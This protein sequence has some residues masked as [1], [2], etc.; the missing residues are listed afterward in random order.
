M[1]PQYGDWCGPGHTAGQNGIAF[2]RADIPFLKLLPVASIQMP[3]G[4]KQPSTLDSACKAHDIAYIEAEGRPNESALKSNADIQLL[5]EITSSFNTYTPEEKVYG[6]MAATAFAAKLALYDLPATTLSGLKN[7]FGKLADYI[8]ENGTPAD[9]FVVTG[10]EHYV[11]SMLVDSWGNV[12]LSRTDDQGTMSLSLGSELDKA[13]FIQQRINEYGEIYD[14]TRINA[15]LQS[16]FFQMS[17]ATDGVEDLQGVVIGKLTQEKLDQFAELGSAALNSTALS[18]TDQSTPSSADPSAASILSTMNVN[19]DNEAVDALDTWFAQADAIVLEPYRWESVDANLQAFWHTGSGEVLAA[20]DLGVALEEAGWTP[21]LGDSSWALPDLAPMFADFSSETGIPDPI[22]LPSYDE[23]LDTYDGFN[24]NYEDYLS[25]SSDL[26]FVTGSDWIS[27]G[28]DYSN[29]YVDP[30]VLKLGAGSVHTTNR[31]GSTV[32]FDMNADGARDKT[33][34]ITA[35]EGFLVIDKNN[36]GIIDNTSEMFSEYLSPKAR[37][38]FGALAA[39]DQNGDGYADKWDKNFGKLKLWIDINVNGVTDQ[40]ELHALNEFGIYAIRT[41]TPK[42]ANHYDN[43][44]LIQS[45][46]SYLANVKGRIHYG[47]VAEVLFNYG[48]QGPIATVYLSDQTSTVRTGSGKVIELLTDKGAQTIN[49]SLSGVNVLIGGAGDRLNAGNAGKSLL[50]GNG[51]TTMNGNAGDVHFIVNG[52]G[53]VVNT[54]SGSSWIEVNG[55]ANKINAT[56]GDVTLDVDGN[57]NAV[58][59]GSGADVVLGGTDNTLTAAAKSHDNDIVVGGEKAIIKVSNADVHIDDHASATLNGKNNDIT[60]DSNAT[61]S[62]KASGGTLTVSGEN[63]VA[64]LTGAFIAMTEG[65]GLTLTGSAHQVVMAGDASLTMKSSGVGSTIYVSGDDNQLN[66][67]RATVILADRAGLDLNGS[68]DRISLLGNAS[69]SATGTA[70]RI[71]AYG[72]GNAV[73][74]EQSTVVEHALAEITLSGTGN[75][76]KVTPDNSPAAPAALGTE[77][78]LQMQLDKAVEN[79]VELALQMPS[80]GIPIDEVSTVGT[81]SLAGSGS[82]LTMPDYMH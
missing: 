21:D 77:L 61:L 56:K 49:A 55:D 12:V 9:P 22:Y 29:S 82:G 2:K 69:L 14:E 60:M 65:S 42:V 43:G 34:W 26:Y 36:N 23:F 24:L 58:A 62:G 31:L 3:D 20:Y 17:H 15:D 40:G 81:L 25:P 46:A 16:T 50:I 33:G 5:K 79:S 4:S 68:A 59:I 57:R 64:T 74:A 70:H 32:M 51:K 80:P 8:A 52:T 71:D 6:A 73:T 37:T 45:T 76:L 35:D 13:E 48:D 30:L 41:K 38:G 18:D 44:N 27:P 66:A 75:V 67:S 72:I 47:E 54:G 53:N 28:Y 10:D 7:D 11:Q 19:I 39:F 63:N 1:I 78:A